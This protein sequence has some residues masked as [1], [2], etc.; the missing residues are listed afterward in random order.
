MWLNS[1]ISFGISG[2]VRVRQLKYRT[3]IQ[4]QMRLQ[5]PSAGKKKAKN[6]K[7]NCAFVL[8]LEH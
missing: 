7:V 4:T 6:G 8:T 5:I 2:S 1:A 3:F